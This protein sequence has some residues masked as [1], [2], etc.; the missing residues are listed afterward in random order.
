MECP[1]ITIFSCCHFIIANFVIEAFFVDMHLTSTA[2]KLK[3]IKNDCSDK[4]D[5]NIDHLRN[6]QVR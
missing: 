5:V 2:V 4:L 3:I 6:T 1:L